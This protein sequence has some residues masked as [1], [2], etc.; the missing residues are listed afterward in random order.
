MIIG[1]KAKFVELVPANPSEVPANCLFVDS[2]NNNT[3]T[4]K[5]QFNLPAEIGTT[6]GTSSL[7]VKTMEAGGLFLINRPL[8]K[9]PDG[10]VVQLDSD[11]PGAN[12]F[13][14]YSLQEATFIGEQ[15]SVLCLGANIVNAVSG[16]GFTAGDILYIGE[17]GEYTNSVSGFTGNNDTI[18][19]V[20]LADCPAGA[21]SPEATDL[22]AIA[23]IIAY[24]F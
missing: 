6:V 10:T 9:K 4:Y 12:N 21:A 20:G 22:I 15:V 2:T 17:N 16:M 7:F 24:P 3:P 1:H 5:N 11:D 18:I 13:C 23:D 8:S 14:A 19:K